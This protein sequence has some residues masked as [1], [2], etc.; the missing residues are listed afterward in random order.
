MICDHKLVHVIPAHAMVIIMLEDAVD[1]Q[2]PEF[3]ECQASF[4]AII[5]VSALTF[6]I[7]RPWLPVD[8]FVTD[9]A[10]ILL[11]NSLPIATV[12]RRDRYIDIQV[13]DESRGIVPFELAPISQNRFR[14]AMT[15]PHIF[16]DIDT[17]F[18]AVGNFIH[19]SIVQSKHHTYPTR[20]LQTHT[21][22]DYQPR[23]DIDNDVNDRYANEATA[24]SRT[25]EMNIANRR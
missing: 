16:S 2:L 22:P 15:G 11:D 8:H 6:C 12:G 25:D 9:K 4:Q 13:I 5:F 14:Q 19:C 18:L 3:G 17:I 1:H 24:V 7:C 20:S 10:K 23:E 21:E